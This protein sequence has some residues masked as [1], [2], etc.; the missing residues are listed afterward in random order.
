MGNIPEPTTPG[1]DQHPHSF[2]SANLPSRRLHHRTAFH[3]LVAV[4]FAI[5][6]ALFVIAIRDLA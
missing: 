4:S 3:R 1:S 2:S 6:N 5:T